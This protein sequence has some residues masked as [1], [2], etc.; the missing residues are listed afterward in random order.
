MVKLLLIED[1]EEIC[2]ELGKFLAKRGGFEVLEATDAIAGMKLYQE[3]KPEI[4]VLDVHLREKRGQKVFEDI[5]KINP[6][7]K[8]VLMS[9]SLE[10]IEELKMH[11]IKA[12]AYF[13]KPFD[14]KE[15]IEALKKLA[16][17]Q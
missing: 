5:R 9:G 10:R 7:A 6:D 2:R 4:T 16:G 3:Q 11:E 12:E 13:L 8:V 17:T 15:F 1:E 14:M